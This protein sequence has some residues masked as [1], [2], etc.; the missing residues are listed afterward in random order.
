M[1]YL[2]KQAAALVLVV[3]VMT[4]GLYAQKH[5]SHPK[6]TKDGKSI[7]FYSRQPENPGH[8][9]VPAKGGTPKLMLADND[10]YHPYLSPDGSKLAFSKKVG[11]LYKIFISDPSGE[12][13]V[14]MQEE[15]PRNAF[16]PEWSENGDQ[17]VFNIENNQESDVFLSKGD[18]SE[19]K[20]ITTDRFATMPTFSP[21]QKSLVF[22]AR[23]GASAYGIYRCDV[24]GENFEEIIADG[25]N[26]FSPVWSPDG[27]FLVF[28]ANID[29]NFDI[30]KMKE[31]GSELT[32]LTKTPEHEFFPR[33]SPNGK[34]IA[35][36]KRYSS[37]DKTVLM[38]M[39]SDGTK[40]AAVYDK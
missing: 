11:D 33:W 3:M 24:D 4:T 17:I 10:G 31:D 8:Y 1:K 9:I 7:V 20:R 22:S 16:H 35:Y 26:Y 18:G 25:R 19:V 2:S 6:W 39:K 27:E 21:D 15:N 14:A 12:N 34:Q 29:G 28:A 32:Q 40:A 38:K 36:I 23:N 37:L 5:D 30:W 13:Q